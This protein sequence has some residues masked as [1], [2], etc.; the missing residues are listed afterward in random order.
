MQFPVPGLNLEEQSH[1]PALTQQQTAVDINNLPEDLRKI[2]E[3]MIAN[4][5]DKVKIGDKPKVIYM[6]DVNNDEN[7]FPFSQMNPEGN[8]QINP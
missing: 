7:Q 8:D 1:I 5:K 3:E 4:S 2:V 6:N